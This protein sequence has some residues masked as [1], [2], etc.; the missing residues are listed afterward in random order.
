[1]VRRWDWL[2]FHLCEIETPSFEVGAIGSFCKVGR[3]YKRLFLTAFIRILGMF[4]TI[5][6]SCKTSYIEWQNIAMCLLL[7]DSIISLILCLLES[8]TFWA[9]LAETNSFFGKNVPLLLKSIFCRAFKPRGSSSW[10]IPWI[11]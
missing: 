4:E 11:K 10:S 1:M 3:V 9:S 7:P 8:I 2:R 5:M 6:S